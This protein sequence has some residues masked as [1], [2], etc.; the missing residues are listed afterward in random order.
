MPSR[1][2]KLVSLFLFV[3]VLVLPNFFVLS[4]EPDASLNLEEICEKICQIEQ[5]PEEVSDEEYKS[6]LRKCEAYYQ[7]KSEEIEKDI[8]KTQKEKKTLQNEIW[9]IR[10]T[11]KKLENQIYQ[12][13][14]MIKD[15]G[16]QI[17]DT[18]GAIGKT[19]LKIGK[20][21]EKLVNI[22]RTIYEEDQKSI[23]ETLL[24]EANLSDFFDNLV[25]LGALG[26]ENK[27]LLGH[28]KNLKL[29]LEEQ[30]GSL[31]SEKQ[32]LEGVVVVRSLQKRENAAAKRK[33]EG[34]LKMTEAE[35]Q[36]SL[37]EKKETQERITKIGNLLF[38]LLEVPSGG[39]KFEDAVEIARSTSLLTGISPG[40]SLAILW[41]ETRI[42]KLKGGCYL[43]D[44]KTGDGIYIKTG[45]KAPRT[46]KP[47]RDISPFEKIIKEL[48]KA[49]K[50]ETDMFHTPVSCCMVLSNGN[51]FGW[52][53][54]M[55]PAQF[56]PSTW[57]LVK[58]E[59]EKKTGNIPANP[60][61]IR[62]AFLANGLYLRDL[63]ANVKTYNA[64][65]N[66][67]LRYF[68]CTS[69]WCRKNYGEPVMAVAECCEQYINNGTMSS[70]CENLIF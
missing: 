16:L 28:I 30:K 65:M 4:E 20:S 66:A 45:N 56:I 70:A 33:Q 59:I 17:E 62:D 38:E 7:E 23:V 54:A 68:G 29:Y 22:L 48:D 8:T 50:I 35:Y 46:M 55:G 51:L 10:N 37:K 49:K 58:Q 13:N 40:F 18:E 27:K 9:S 44:K 34:L 26:A 14:L 32:E 2:L 52:G 64:E 69:S 6:L 5:K 57:M 21:Q 31:D 60:W 25:A 3:S 39:I 53:G 42:G 1:I 12:S 11:I 41:Q 63:G 36:Q 43:R 47:S 19:S 15:L 67:A 61:D 24:S